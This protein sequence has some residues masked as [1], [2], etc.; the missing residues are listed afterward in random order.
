MFYFASKVLFIFFSYFYKTVPIISDQAGS[1]GLSD[2]KNF[3]E[4]SL[5]NMIDESSASLRFL[6]DYFE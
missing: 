4:K 5:G 3:A 2:Q 6:I 1:L